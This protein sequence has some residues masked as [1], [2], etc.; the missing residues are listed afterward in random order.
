MSLWKA[1]SRGQT[2]VLF[3]CFIAVA[4]MML[5]LTFFLYSA[6][7]QRDAAEEI[8]RAAVRAG[9][10]Q[11]DEEKMGQGIVWLDTER[12]RS[13]ALK[14]LRNGLPYLPYG[15]S[16]GATPDSIIAGAEIYV[17][18]A[19]PGA[20][21]E[22]PLSH[23]VYDRPFVAIRI[24]VPTAAFFGPIDLGIVQEDTAFLRVTP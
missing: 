14:V 15:L 21:H 5:S 4:A 20:P 6:K 9:C 17:V 1:R 2:L 18:N 24:L 23:K 10:M 3:A 16:G 22:S 11:V 13:A 7:R 8:A 12:A 19:T